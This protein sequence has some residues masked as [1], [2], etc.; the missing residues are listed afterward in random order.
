MW[1]EERGSDYCTWPKTVCFRVSIAPYD[2]RKRRYDRL[3][4]P[5]EAQHCRGTALVGDD[6]GVCD[7]GSLSSLLR[8]ECDED[9]GS[10]GIGRPG[11]RKENN[12]LAFIASCGG[13]DRL[14]RCIVKRMREVGCE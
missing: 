3:L 14:W 13:R 7:K 1:V 5:S 6:R 8:L 2:F 9:K 10:V 12:E 4:T 11:V